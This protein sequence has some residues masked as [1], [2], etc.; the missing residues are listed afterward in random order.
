MT[1]KILT[2]ALLVF[3]ATS[4]FGSRSRAVSTG[5]G[6]GH[7]DAK[8]VDGGTVSGIIESVNGNI[9]TLAG[10]LITI[11][12][13]DAK[14]VENRGRIDSLSDLKPGML[15]F[16]TISS[17][18]VP[19]NAPLEAS[20][21]AVTPLPDATLFGT[22]QNVDV[23][24]RQFTIL[25][26]T[27]QVTND[28]SW[29]GFNSVA[30]PSISILMNGHLVQVQADNV[31]GKLTATSVILVSPIPPSVQHARGTVASIGNDAWVI[32]REREPN[33]RVVVNAQ[34]KIIGSPK[35]GDKVEVLYNVST[36]N[37]NIAISIAA[38]NRDPDPPNNQNFLF[39]GTVKTIDTHAWVITVS[40][41]REVKVGINRLTKIEDGIK[42]GDKVEVIA[43]GEGDNLTALVIVKKR[44]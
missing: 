3:T 7:V 6:S 34:T 19:A 32:D 29:G 11:D 31:N 18:D 13:S 20:M 8:R 17:G 27:I 12:A 4:V 1:R 38:F 22:V 16:A 23:P 5:T 44:F 42:I 39:N 36:A 14:I 35:V 2:L 9:I 37:E 15:L 43:I 24:N 33:L 40:A 30:P 21:I 41:E 26:R 28:T 10:G 25:G